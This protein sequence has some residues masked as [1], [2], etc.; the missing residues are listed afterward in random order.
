L[1]LKM[2]RPS[3]IKESMMSDFTHIDEAG[4]PR[5]VDIGSKQV[6]ERLAV[7][8]CKVV[9]GQGIIS[10]MV[11]GD[12]MSKKGSVIQ[13]ATIAGIMGTKKTPELIPMCHP[14]S[15]SHASIK[16]YE[17]D[18][19]SLKVECTCKIEGKTGVEMEAMQGA[20]TAALT[21]Y[22]MCKSQNPG[23]IITDLKLEKKTG[24]KSDF[25]SA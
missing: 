18:E 4:R 22:D 11:D 24:G 21:L 6:S 10:Q 3:Y 7:A 13:T 23:I 12:L 15:L 16:I 25:Q 9:L 2:L 19:E 20:S 1:A 14:L 5:M 17:L 8:S